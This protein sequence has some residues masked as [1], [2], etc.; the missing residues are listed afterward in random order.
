MVLKKQKIIFKEL[1]LIEYKEALRYQKLL[2]AENI[3]K[4]VNKQKTNNYFL[5]C[6]HPHVYTLGNSGN[7]NNL[8]INEEVLKKINASLFKTNRGGD[9][10]YHG[11][12][13]IIAYIVLDLDNFG[14]GIKK[15]IYN[16][17]EVIINLLSKY[18]IE[19]QISIGNIGVW[20]DV[21]KMYERKICSIGVNISR[22]IT[23]HGF[24]LNVNTDLSYFK[25]INACG[26]INKGITSMKKE[27]N[28]R[29][30]LEDIKDLISCE[31]KKI[32]N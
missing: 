22:G 15:Y 28:S 31:F 27:L 8:L 16:I 5:F 11:P 12:G 1:G 2:F 9:I 4:K 26:F 29:L 3:K 7:E 20:L 32:F 13:Q 6:E 23:M 21:D 25:Y 14:I 19:G 10:T 18:K 17:E 24:A 30:N